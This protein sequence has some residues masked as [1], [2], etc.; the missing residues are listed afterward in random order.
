M[1]RTLLQRAAVRAALTVTLAVTLAP[2]LPA[3]E[4][5]GASA[6][7][8]SSPTEDFIKRT[9]N[10]TDWLSWGADLRVRDEY[11]DNA[12]TLTEAS[13]VSEM[14]VIRTRGRV[15]ASVTPLTNVSLNTRLSAEPRIWTKPGG[16]G[17]MRGQSGTEWRYGIFDNLNGK[18]NNMFDTGLSLTAG[19][20]DIAF[21]DYW[22]WWLVADGTP[23]DGSWTFFLDSIRLSYDWKP[24]KTKIDAIYLYQNARPDD[25]IPTLGR[26]RDSYYLTEQNEQG[27]MF[28]VSTKAIEDATLDGYF[29]YKRDD[30][31]L[32]NGDS[33]D[34]YTLGARIAGVLADHWAYSLEG[35]YQFGNKEDRILGQTARRDIDAYGANARFGY[36]FKDKMNNRIDLI[37]EF[38]SGDDPTTGEDEMFDILWGRWPRFSELYIYSYAAETSGK[39]AQLN[40]IERVGL[41]WTMNP[42]KGMTVQAVYNAMFAPEQVPTRAVAPLFSGDGDFRGHYLQAILKHQFGKHMNAHLWGEFIWEGDYYA[43]R[44]LMTFLR[45]E[46]MFT[47]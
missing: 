24:A 42:M 20:Q 36:L 40:N 16:Y 27:V 2:T 46:V 47:W 39:V 8:P 37:F 30:Q 10:P 26:S 1:K 22:N 43:Q 23:G 28:Y 32:S 41:G 35:A 21:G 5:A 9:K 33:A 13:P 12:V 11:M 6:P 38:L 3:A 17:P 44:D 4:K 19:R 45:A 7:P 14:N 15:W 34:I 31:E 29:I 25:W 18:W